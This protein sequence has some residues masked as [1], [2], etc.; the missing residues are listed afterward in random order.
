MMRNLST[1]LA[2]YNISVND[3]SPAMIGSTGMIKDEH[4]V[5]G[6]VDTIPVH[7]LGQ[8]KEVANVVLMFAKT[9][10]ATGQSF[11]LAGGL[12]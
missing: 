10:Y 4:S 1:R 8:P 12:K 3:V 2:K 6:L 11:L 5:P 9:G 7:R